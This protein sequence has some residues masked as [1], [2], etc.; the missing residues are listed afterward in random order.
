M[1]PMTPQ[2]LHAAADELLA[3]VFSLNPEAKHC[4]DGCRL[5]HCCYEPAYADVREIRH[6]LEGLSPEQK[7]A[8]KARLPDWLEKA[9]PLLHE[10][11]P[12][13]MGYRLLAVPCPLL[14]LK[15]NECMAYDRR[16]FACRTFL[17]KENPSRCATEHRQTQK[18][19]IFPVV[20]AILAQYYVS[21]E[22]LVMD[23]IGALLIEELLATTCR[24]GSRVSLPTT[25]PK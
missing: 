9:R 19:G 5:A 3:K 15:T 7:E 22:W 21:N 23:H 25:Q 10:D 12:S 13:A 18:Y 2:K 6:L 17:A 4:C 11:M 8:V 20:D 14:N 1:T 16:P 24:T